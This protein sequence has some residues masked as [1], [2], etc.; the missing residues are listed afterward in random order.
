[1]IY[2]ECCKKT[3][4]RLSP[5]VPKPENPDGFGGKQN[6]GSK[7]PIWR[8]ETWAFIS[9]K[10]L[11]EAGVHSDIRQEDGIRKWLRTSTQRE[12]VFYIIDLQKSVGMV[13]D[14]YKARF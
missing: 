9:M 13:D 4:M 1:M 3:R 12:M 7:K 14:A 10:Q 8:K 6:S 5:S 2:Y 11:L